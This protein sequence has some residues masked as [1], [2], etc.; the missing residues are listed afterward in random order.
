M[1]VRFPELPALPDNT[2]PNLREWCEAV[3]GQLGIMRGIIAPGTNTR[4]VTIQDLVNA[5]LVADGVIR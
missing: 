2:P 1:T 4:F 3:E 5:A